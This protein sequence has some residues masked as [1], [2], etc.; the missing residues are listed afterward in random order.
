[1][2]QILLIAI[3]LSMDAFAVSISSG[4]CVPHM[5]LRFAI[6]AAFAFGFFQF[7]MPVV[8]W[9]LGGTFRASIEGVDH[10]I[11][12]FLL[13]FV[14]GKMIYES[15]GIKDEEG[16]C[17]DQGNPITGIMKLGTLLVLAIA[18]S[19]DALAV[20]L[21]FS[22]LD[23]PILAPS[24]VIGVITFGLSLVG[25]EFGKKIGEKAERWAELGGGI[26][27][28]GIAIKILVEHLLA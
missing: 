3:G 18:T 15:F 12:F 1:M 11:A 9:L 13:V 14:G 7:M 24:I 8:G 5:K 28:V 23:T 22:M 20:G 17:D 4:I 21:S 6:R 26:V 10:W 16:A 19:I 2:L 25:I 27:L